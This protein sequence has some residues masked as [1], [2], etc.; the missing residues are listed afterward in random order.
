MMAQMRVFYDH[1]SKS[2]AQMKV[3][4]CSDEYSSGSFERRRDYYG[5]IVYDPV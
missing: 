1:L 2:I 4:C 3:F 5:A